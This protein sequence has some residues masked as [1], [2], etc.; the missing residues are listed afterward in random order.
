M[1][2]KTNRAPWS[3]VDAFTPGVAQCPHRW[4][5]HRVGDVVVACRDPDEPMTFCARCYVPRCTVRFNVPPAS[6]GVKAAQLVILG[7]M[8]GFVACCEQPVYH[9]VPHVFRT[10]AGW[11][12]IEIGA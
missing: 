3:G 12:T 7:I 5:T 2:T 9:V 1:A 6:I 4:V 11:H 8:P 10:G